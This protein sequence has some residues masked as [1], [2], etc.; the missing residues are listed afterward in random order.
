M[1]AKVGPLATKWEPDLNQQ[2]CDVV[3]E[4]YDAH[5]AANYEVLRRGWRRKE[6]W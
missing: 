2:R 4:A 1:A 3:F 6:V 5:F